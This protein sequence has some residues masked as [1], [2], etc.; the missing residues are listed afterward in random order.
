[1]NACVCENN[2]IYQIAQTIPNMIL[3]DRGSGTRPDPT[4]DKLYIRE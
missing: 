2:N 3:S 1:M 4:Y